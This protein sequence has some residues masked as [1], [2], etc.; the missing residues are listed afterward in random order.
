MH[1]LRE[2]ESEVSCRYNYEKFVRAPLILE[3]KN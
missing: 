3:R 1:A 2:L